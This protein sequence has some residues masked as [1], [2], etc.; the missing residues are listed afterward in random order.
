[1]P[2]LAPR[3]S[4]PRG[5]MDILVIGAGLAGLSV[6]YHLAPHG[7][8]RVIEQRDQPG[9]EASAQNAGMIRRMGEDPYERALALRTHARLADPPEDLARHAPSRRTGAVLAL[10]DDPWHLH[11]AAAHL[12]ARGVTVEQVN[13]P[14]R[15]A[16]ILAGSPVAH[17]W[18]LPDERVADAHAL[19]S[20]F[21]EG[22]R[23]HDGEVRCGEAVHEL[24]LDGG[25]VTGVRTD[26]GLLH[27]DAVVLAAGAWSGALAARAGLQ[28]PLV[29]LRRTLAQTEADP[30]SEGHPWVWLDDV[31]IYLRPD[32]GGWLLSGCDE[33]I[34]PPDDGPS[35]GPIEAETRALALHKLERFLPRFGLP[36]LR[37]GWTGLRTFAPDR[38]PMLGEDPEAPGLWWA[39]G[40]GGFGVTCSLGVGEAVAA[41][42]R[43]EEV[44]WLDRAAVSPGRRTLRRW[45]IRPT[46]DLAGSKLIRVE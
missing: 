11:D 1:M 45:A 37:T 3:R 39:A 19:V 20:G 10:V 38:R 34:D 41:W 27:A 26:R 2:D 17:A 25:R 43:A 15:V 29:P 44:P 12:R 14:A 9:T 28:R 13:E 35:R 24:V 36:R 8:V 21:L 33:A 22:I 7:R 32:S 42:L 40:L 16:P 6:A 31:G 23:A 5:P 4:G 18:Y 30:R 46:G